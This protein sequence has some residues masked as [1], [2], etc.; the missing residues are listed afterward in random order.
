M[1]IDA[2]TEEG[3]LIL[4]PEAQRL[5]ASNAA[6][7]REQ[8]IGF[9]DAGAGGAM[10]LDLSGVKFVDSSALGSLIAA[11]KRL[12]PLGK[13]AIA[14]VQPAVARLFAVTRMDRVFALHPDT[15]GAVAAL[16]VG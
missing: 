13:L 8:L 5:D 15:A 12:G 4:T 16:S 10:V 7:F 11:V 6:V 2:R 9:I 1:R 14:G 3:V